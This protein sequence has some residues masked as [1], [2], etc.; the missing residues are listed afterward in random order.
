[1]VFNPCNKQKNANVILLIIMFRH[2][3]QDVNSHL[4]VVAPLMAYTTSVA[5]QNRMG[6]KN[7]LE[8]QGGERC[9]TKMG[10][11]ATELN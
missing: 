10:T 9:N 3:K 8:Q 2:L 6:F 4:T 1:M 7:K 5:N 11:S